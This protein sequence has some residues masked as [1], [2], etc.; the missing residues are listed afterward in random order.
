MPN[1]KRSLLTGV[2]AIAIAVAIV[3]GAYWVMSGGAAPKDMDDEATSTPAPDGVTTGD[4]KIGADAYALTDMNGKPITEKSFPGKFKLVFFGFT[5]CADICPLA[6]QNIAHALK[7]MG[8][9]AAKFQVLFIS[10]DPKRDTPS[11]LK[12]YLK[13][14]SPDILGATGTPAQVKIAEDSFRV[15]ASDGKAEVEDGDEA[16]HDGHHHMDMGADDKDVVNH[17]DNIYLLK[18]GNELVSVF[19][20]DIDEGSLVKAIKEALSK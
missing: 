11:V 19:N 17:S 13:N 4:I 7:D 14:F 6:L 9:D 3:G 20:G 18:P 5:N 16:E 12:N 15:Y 8:A 1:T 10:V 2:T